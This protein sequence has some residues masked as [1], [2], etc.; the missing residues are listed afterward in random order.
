MLIWKSTHNT[1][2][3]NQLKRKNKKP[4]LKPPI[5]P[6]PKTIQIS[7]PAPHIYPIN[8]KIS[9]IYIV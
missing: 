1:P 7:P 2:I 9:I 4:Q 3:I 6:R 5:K 8:S